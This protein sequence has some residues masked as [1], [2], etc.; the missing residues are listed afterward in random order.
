MQNKIFMTL[1]CLSTILDRNR[2]DMAVKPPN[3]SK[4]HGDKLKCFLPL[5]CVKGTP[6]DY[7]RMSVVSACSLLCRWFI[8]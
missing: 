8:N 1:C 4:K 6:T 3:E 5:P 7:S 2:R